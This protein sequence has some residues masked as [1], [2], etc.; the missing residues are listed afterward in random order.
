ME[1][2]EINKVIP[3]NEQFRNDLISL[4]KDNTMVEKLADDIISLFRDKGK[5]GKSPNCQCKDSQDSY[6][7]LH[8]GKPTGKIICF[9]CD[10]PYSGISL[11]D[12]DKVKDEIQLFW[13]SK[14]LDNNSGLYP[15]V[16][17][18]WYWNKLGKKFK[19]KACTCKGDL[20]DVEGT[21]TYEPTDFY[22]VTEGEYKGNVIL[23]K[24]CKIQ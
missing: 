12:V 11:S 7:Q 8:R 23:K 3:A 4:I 13:D 16:S 6:A 17:N 18:F 1:K 15:A 9:D 19:V 21:H 2:K 10:K 22:M 20:N 14:N 24:H 5:Y